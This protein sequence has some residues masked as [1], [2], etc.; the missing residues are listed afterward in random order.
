MKKPLKKWACGVCDDVHDDERDA[1]DCCHPS[2]FEVWEC[3]EC[4]DTH[5]TEKE[6]ELCCGAEEGEEQDP[7]RLPPQHV[8]E[9]AGQ[10]RL[11]PA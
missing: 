9:S 6:A 7:L 8:L 3:P 2:P 5:D 10:M 4:E 1:E 11:L